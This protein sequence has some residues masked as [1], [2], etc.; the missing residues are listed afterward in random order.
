M[1]MEDSSLFLP[2][3]TTTTLQSTSYQNVVHKK[4]KGTLI[5]NEE[6]L[7]F[8]PSSS[9]A[10][11]AG[12]DLSTA[13]VNGMGQH[14]NV[15]KKY[16]HS[17]MTIGKH[18]VSPAS[19]PRHLLKVLLNVTP[20]TSTTTTTTSTSSFVTFEFSTRMELE[21]IRTDVSDRL[22]VARKIHALN[23]SASGSATESAS[24]GTSRKRKLENVHREDTSGMSP[25]E[26]QETSASSTSSSSSSCQNFT[27]LL[28]SELC[29]TCSSILASDRNV[30]TQHLLLTTGTAA[31]TGTGGTGGGEMEQHAA[32]MD[33]NS[34]T[35]NPPNDTTTVVMEEQDFWSTHSTQ[36]SHQSAKILGCISQGIPSAM[37]SSLDIQLTSH[38]NSVSKPIKLGVEEMRQIFIMYPAVYEAYEEKVP[39]E[40]SE[41][42]FWRKY[43][44]SEYFHRDRGRI[45]VSARPVD[46]MT[47]QQD[48]QSSLL[49]VSQ[50]QQQGE[51]TSSDATTRQEGGGEKKLQ[52]EETKKA[53]EREESARLGAASSN[54]I[55]S[56]KELELNRIKE[57]AVKNKLPRQQQQQQQPKL[58]VGQ[59]DLMATANTERGSKLLLGSTNDLHPFDDRGKKVIEKYNRHW[60]MVLNPNDAS[61]G[62]DLKALAKKSVQYAL[63]DDDDAK[64][65]G[66]FGKEMQRLVGF[67]SADDD[68]VDHVKGIGRR[69][70]GDVDNDEPYSEEPV[71]YEELNLRNVNAYSGNKDST[72]TSSSTMVDDATSLSNPQVNKQDVVFAQLAM[73]QIKALIAPILDSKKG[74][75]TPSP[76]ND[77]MSPNYNH[78]HVR[79]A[80]PDPKF[81]RELL[82]ALTKHMVLDSMTDKD[83]AKMTKSLPEEF[84]KRLTS[85]TRRANEL[86][87]HFF[88]LRHVIQEE[89]KET[90]TTTTT[91]STKTTSSTLNQSASTTMKL[92]RI[93]QGLED[94]YREMEGMRKDLPQT[95]LGEKMRKMCLP[96]MDQ[97][98]WAFKLN[99]DSSGSGGGF[100]TV[101]D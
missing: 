41:E 87:R 75:T 66:G 82:M 38:N 33:S 92:K 73:D 65:N 64:V 10:G 54:D 53:K 32:G 35:T 96:I 37:K 52:E 70:G 59:F 86:L 60:A 47:T 69:Y 42:Q 58:A 74:T 28:P 97:L 88:A 84:R 95:E 62:C 77:A 24:G 93:V 21:R 79:N 23:T 56:R 48:A 90:R 18:Q 55:F 83:T 94:V 4:I 68:H 25:K 16:R 3:V 71:L 100:V 29:V 34:V 13:V 99:R 44:E 45:G 39:L 30:R 76:N 15:D 2:V 5:L 63:Q 78:H 20:S 40:L 43:L 12:G 91:T 14:S 67:A 27:T 26:L 1:T 51:F 19:H 50:S 11:G 8:Y 72:T 85:Y 49:Q 7:T 80:M 9:V 6:A 31:D 98:D 36:I 46:M 22:M 81:G 89:K 17:W 57:L 61:A 101:N